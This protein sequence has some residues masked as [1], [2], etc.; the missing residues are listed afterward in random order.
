MHSSAIFSRETSTQNHLHPEQHIFM[1][2]SMSKLHKK[3]VPC[4]ALN[5]DWFFLFKYILSR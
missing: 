3:A 2:K 5:F 1:K 4:K